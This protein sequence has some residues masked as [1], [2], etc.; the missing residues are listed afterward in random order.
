[1]EAF[2]DYDFYASDYGGADVPTTDFP[3]LAYMA[4][5]E[6]NTQTLERAETVMSEGTDTSLMDK[7]KMATCA[8]IDVM[9]EGEQSQYSSHVA[10]E[11]IGDHAVT[12]TSAEVVAHYE[13]A[14]LHD[15]IYRYL[16]L[17]GLMFAGV[18]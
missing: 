14:K 2:V 3:K 8:V 17:T 6:V 16:G 4:S 9:Y 13:T 11:K 1:M 7:I 18:G 12:Y 10:S 15:A 5:F